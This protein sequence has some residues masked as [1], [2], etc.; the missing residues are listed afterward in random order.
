MCPR[1]NVRAKLNQLFQE[2]ATA[3]LNEGDWS[4]AVKLWDTRPHYDIGIANEG[5]VIRNSDQPGKVEPA[6]MKWGLIPSWSKDGKPI[7]G[8]FN[9]RGETVATKPTFRT[10][11]KNRRCL[12]PSD[13]FYEWLW[14]DEKGKSKQKYHIHLTGDRPFVFAGIW[15]RW[16]R[17][18]TTVESY[19]MVTTEPNE[20]MTQLHNRMPVILT[21]AEARLW[22]DPK[23]PDKALLGLLDPYPADE[24]EAWPVANQPNGKARYDGPEAVERIAVAGV[25]FGAMA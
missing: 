14:L 16:K 2:L 22:L 19:S 15:D 21:P 18:D 25:P 7:P 12:I 20:L 10:P 3:A 17:D 24:V 1:Y 9:A 6:V 23:T 11:F 8:A 4:E 5:L 13:G